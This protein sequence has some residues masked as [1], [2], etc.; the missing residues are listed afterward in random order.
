M[1]PLIL[2]VLNWNYST[3]Y[4]NPYYELLLQRGASAKRK[5]GQNFDKPRLPKSAA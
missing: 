1:F 5:V 4:Y 3:P 2:T